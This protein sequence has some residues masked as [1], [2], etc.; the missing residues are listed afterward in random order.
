[1]MMWDHRPT[2]DKTAITTRYLAR[3]RL[4]LAGRRAAPPHG[5]EDWELL[6]PMIEICI[7][8]QHQGEGNEVFAVYRVTVSSPDSGREP[9][10]YVV[11]YSHLRKLS[12]LLP[13]VR[14]LFPRPRW[15]DS[16]RYR[17]DVAAQREPL[18]QKWLLRACDSLYEPKI[19]EFI[20]KRNQVASILRSSDGASSLFGGSNM[21]SRNETTIDSGQ[22]RSSPSTL[23][24]VCAEAPA[25]TSSDHPPPQRHRQSAPSRPEEEEEAEAELEEQR[26]SD[27]RAIRE[28]LASRF[29]GQEAVKEQCVKLVFL[30]DRTQ[31]TGG[32]LDNLNFVMTGNPGTGK[33]QMAGILSEI[34]RRYGAIRS[35]AVVVTNGY[36]ITAEYEGQTKIKT[37]RKID[38]AVDKGGVLFIDEAYTMTKSKYGHEAFE[39]LML[40]MSEHPGSPAIVFAGYQ[41][42]M[43]RLEQVNV[44]FNRR[45]GY[46]FRFRDFT[47]DEIAD[48]FYMQTSKAGLL[49]PMIRADAVRD[50]FRRAFPSRTYNAEQNAGLAQT[51]RRI[52]DVTVGQAGFGVDRADKLLVSHEHLELAVTEARHEASATLADRLE[53]ETDPSKAAHIREMAF[54]L[55]ALQVCLVGVREVEREAG[56]P[57]MTYMLRSVARDGKR[58]LR[59]QTF[60]AFIKLQSKLSSSSPRHGGTAELIAAASRLLPSREGGVR[61]STPEERRAL[62]ERRKDALEDWLQQLAHATRSC[63]TLPVELCRFLGMVPSELEERARRHSGAGGEGGLLSL[64]FHD[65]SDNEEHEHDE[66]RAEM[67]GWKVTSV[68]PQWPHREGGGSGEKVTYVRYRVNVSTP[69]GVSFQ[70]STRWSEVIKLDEKVRKHQVMTDLKALPQLPRALW[71]NPLT[72]KV[73]E[74]RRKSMLMYLQHLVASNELLHLPVVDRFFD[75]RASPSWAAAAGTNALIVTAHGRTSSSGGRDTAGEGMGRPSPG[76]STTFL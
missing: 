70:V 55:A 63:E 72:Q 38:E 35:T 17:M 16:F 67:S 24:V 19:I 45:V 32:K 10:F 13:E 31:K 69:S 43:A 11:R 61:Q 71:Q 33:T 75:G 40:R 5:S 18:L 76:L 46:R 51:F 73:V 37:Q 28:W 68:E 48:I 3:N 64:D 4:R 41:T 59:G 29:V 58:F 65:G 50:A 21:P 14:R 36:D 62:A 30:L 60:S 53:S 39:L 8:G 27:D 34:L 22:L 20:K 52:V 26:F 74:E 1:M 12:R 25:A 44:G 15:L 2:A 23:A 42:D 6:V 7:H 57:K 9:D 56:T 47:S 66:T 49:S 54:E